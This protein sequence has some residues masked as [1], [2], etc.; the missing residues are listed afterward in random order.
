MEELLKSA[1]PIIKAVFGHD[2]AD[3]TGKKATLAQAAQKWDADYEAL[4]SQDPP[5]ADPVP[6]AADPVPPETPPVD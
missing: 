4:K 5:H 6:P 3:P 1:A 2:W